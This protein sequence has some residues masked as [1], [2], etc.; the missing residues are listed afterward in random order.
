LDKG[1]L[2]Y[3]GSINDAVEYYLHS[4]SSTIQDT[5]EDRRER[6][7]NQAI[8]FVDAWLQQNGQPRRNVITPFVDVELSV[9]CRNDSGSA[10]DS[11][12]LKL[13]VRVNDILETKITWLS[14]DLRPVGQQS[15]AEGNLFSFVFKI[16]NVNMR[17]GQ[18]NVSLFLVYKGDI[19][20]WIQ[21]AFDF[22]VSSVDSYGNGKTMP[23]NQ[24][25]VMYDYELTMNVRI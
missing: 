24:G 12:F 6:D 21:S 17:P 4:K 8:K 3:S 2:L 5:L 13:D 18:F 22:E 16:K 10:L 7:G 23:A 25:V 19:A 9:L 20:D 1:K 14:T 15:V 11:S